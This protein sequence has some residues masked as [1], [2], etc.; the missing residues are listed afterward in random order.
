MRPIKNQYV[1]IER[2][3]REPMHNFFGYYDI[4]P[5]S[6]DNEYHLCH[7]TEFCDRMQHLTDA[8]EIGMI[9]LYDNAFIP[10][11]RTYAW[12][13]QQGALLQWHPKYPNDK[14]IYNSVYGDEHLCERFSAVIQDVK[15]GEK[16]ILPMALANASPDGSFAL[17]INFARVYWLR[18]GYGYAGINDRFAS[19]PHPSEDGIWRVDLETGEL[20]LIISTDELFNLCEPYMTENERKMKYA[21]NH[22]NLN[23]DGSR[24]I[25]LFRGRSDLGA[26]TVYVTFTVTLN[27]DGSEPYVLLSHSGSH[28]HWRDR[29]N[30]LIWSKPEGAEHPDFYLLKDKTEEHTLFDKKELIGRNGHVSFSP[31][32]RYVLNDTYPLEDGYIKLSLYDTVTEERIPLADI[33]SPRLRMLPCEDVRC[34]LHPRWSGDGSMISF[35]SVHEGHRHIYRIRTE[36]IIK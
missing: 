2:I 23:T 19:E 12:N 18:P 35:D 3:T 16:R 32:R 33:A 5:F 21:V 24:M 29:E 20:E 30:V 14:I 36:D 26:N 7:R 31:D 6:S 11:A 22:V 8:A 34:D 1:P 15:T 27:S 28:L 10:L 4:Q 25:V 9:R 17:G 13:W